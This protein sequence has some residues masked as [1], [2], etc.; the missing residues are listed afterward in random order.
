MNL[1]ERERDR[2]RSM[3]LE[4]EKRSY[5]RRERTVMA[6]IRVPA[7][8]P[9]FHFSCLVNQEVD[10]HPILAMK[11]SMLTPFTVAAVK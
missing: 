10:T 4:R 6:A 8:K 11:F 1:E 2:K 3:E 5:K 7:V 9:T